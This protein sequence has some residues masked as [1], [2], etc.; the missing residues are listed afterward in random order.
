MSGNQQW[1]RIGLA[2]R[3]LEDLLGKPPPSYEVEKRMVD[4]FKSNWA[5]RLLKMSTWGDTTYERFA[6]EAKVGQGWGLYR[7]LCLV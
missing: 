1:N 5:G 4:A 3:L 2:R 6:E 7:P